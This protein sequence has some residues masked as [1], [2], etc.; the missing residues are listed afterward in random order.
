M[1]DR[2]APPSHV[3][4]R[5]APR[6][7]DFLANVHGLSDA[8]LRA[9]IDGQLDAFAYVLAGKR[10]WGTRDEIAAGLEVLAGEL[11]ARHERGRR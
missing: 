2:P 5:C 8:H 7:D 11:R 1:S 6:H 10:A 3:N 4:C 9:A